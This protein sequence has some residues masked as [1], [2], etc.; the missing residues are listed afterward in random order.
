M[1]VDINCD[2][3]EGYGPYTIGD[4]AAM[5]G[6]VS[7]A[8][9]ACGFH[10]G[11]PVIMDKVVRQA[12]SC[13]V[14][15]GA[16]VGFDDRAGF[17]RRLIPLSHVEIEKMVLYQLG[18]LHAIATAADHR[19][20]HMSF[21][22]ALGNLS[23]VDRA[24]SEVLVGATRAFDPALAVLVVPNTELEQ[25]TER[26]GMRAIRTFLAD[27]AYD[28]KGRLVSRQVSGALIE[29]PDEIAARVAQAITERTVRTI[30]GKLLTMSHESILVHGD[31]P[32]AVE[33]ARTVRTTVERLGIRITPLSRMGIPG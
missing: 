11:D 25:A 2:L 7:S 32:H 28:E 24:I 8:N 30:E 20:T 19:V 22:G 12:R 10:A 16:H 15:V 31:T 27:R 5:L 21:H 18:A 4:D 29:N 14:D 9:V 3:G 23:L 13:G 1:K 26:A 6:I 17:G 33:I